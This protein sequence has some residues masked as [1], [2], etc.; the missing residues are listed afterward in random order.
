MVQ[1]SEDLQVFEDRYEI[2][3]EL[4]RGGMG[5]VYKAYDREL[6]MNVA[7]KVLPDEL[8]N[9]KRAITDLKREAKLAMQLRH[10]NIAALYHFAHSGETKFLVMELLEGQSLEDRL[11]EKEVLDLE[12]VQIIAKQLAS[13]LDYAHGEKVVH[14]D[15]K[16]DNI[17]LHIKNDDEEVRIMDFGI[18]RQIKDSM[19]RLTRQDS[20][21]TLLYM[22][23]EQLQGK[24]TDGRADIY[25]LGATLYECLAGTPPFYQGGIEYQ[26]VNNA[27]QPID[28]MPEE[29]NAALLK[30]LAKLP[31]ERFATATDFAKALAGIEVAA[32]AEGAAEEEE[33]VYADL[34]PIPASVKVELQG[35]NEDLD[36]TGD[37]DT[38]DLGHVEAGD[39]C[40][41]L[42]TLEVT[43]MTEAG[44]DEELCPPHI[45]FRVNN[46]IFETITVDND[47]LLLV[48]QETSYLVPLTIDEALAIA[49]GLPTQSKPA[50]VI[51]NTKIIAA[52]GQVATEESAPSASSLDAN[53][54]PDLPP[55]LTIELQGI[56]QEIEYTGEYECIELGHP[57]APDL[58]EILQRMEAME[59]RDPGPDEDLCPAALFY[60]WG[61]GDSD[62]ANVIA[63]GGALT[64]CYQDGPVDWEPMTVE[65]ALQAA[66]DLPQGNQPAT[67][68]GGK[69]APSSQQ[70]PV[71]ADAEKR[72]EKLLN[73][74]ASYLDVSGRCE[75][76]KVWKGQGCFGVTC[77]FIPLG[78]F[79]AFLVVT[80]GNS[81]EVPSGVGVG[82]LIFCI[83]L[84]SLLWGKENL[85]VGIDKPSDCL[86]VK[87]GNKRYAQKYLSEMAEAVVTLAPGEDGGFDV[88][89]RLQGKERPWPIEGLQMAMKGEANKVAD[90]INRL[91]A[92]R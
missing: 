84:A 80:E 5:I 92:S 38:I 76:M 46:D 48:D 8:T 68:G 74:T 67:S 1:E 28:E 63:T 89:I 16:P 70:A 24:R 9:S 19:T 55:N 73:S 88:C 62:W 53:N 59:V 43:K 81:S 69:A 82:L 32:S 60:R 86:F 22:P 15:I 4:G 41:M 77:S 52:G 13:A 31:D 12:E 91:L 35:V 49:A 17:F 72:R 30:A 47:E 42:A 7:I 18:A 79:I 20:S 71:S 14:R 2:I 36:F 83:G 58:L 87:R 50:S 37:F 33:D 21:G 34:Q 23:P 6:E 66:Y 90:L 11:Q 51:E 40:D 26:I 75:N 39:L 27:P 45:I 57:S 78:F 65:E 3:E 44:P 56:S 29:V 64:F 85:E 10:P 54:L 61:E 25:A